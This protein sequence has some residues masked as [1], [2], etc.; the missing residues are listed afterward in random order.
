MGTVMLYQ[1]TGVDIPILLGRKSYR[2]LKRRFNT[3][4]YMFNS[5][6]IA[7]KKEYYKEGANY[8]RPEKVVR[9]LDAYQSSSKKKLTREQVEKVLHLSMIVD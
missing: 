2:K 4:C 3:W 7:F 5:V 1:K 9:A 8:K 6:G